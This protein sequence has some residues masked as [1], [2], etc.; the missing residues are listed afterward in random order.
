MSIKRITV[1][2]NKEI[3]PFQHIRFEVEATVPKDDDKESVTDEIETFLEARLESF[4][5]KLYPKRPWPSIANV[6]MKT[7]IPLPGE[8]NPSVSPY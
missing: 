2:F 4:S 6:P 5:K 1:R 7:S 3:L 8:E